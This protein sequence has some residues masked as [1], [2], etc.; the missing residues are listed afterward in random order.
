MGIV[1][2]MKFVD[3]DKWKQRPT[4]IKCVTLK[5]DGVRVHMK[6]GKP[7]SRKGKPLYGIPPMP[8]GIYE[9]YDH[10]LGFDGISGHVRTIESNDLDEKCLYKIYP[11]VDERLIVQDSCIKTAYKTA[12]DEGYEG[13]VLHT[14]DY[15]VK[16]KPKQTYDVEVLSVTEGTGRHSGRVGALITS[17]GK[18]GTGLTDRD[19]ERTDWVGKLIEVE[20]MG[21]TKNGKFRHPRF[22]RERWDK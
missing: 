13:L 9:A 10:S 20:C 4:H 1:I 12:I 22:I 8:D 18:V 6:D 19:R 3:Y 17:M 7:V 21:L 14:E 15:Y 5:L 2:D 16:L 11:E